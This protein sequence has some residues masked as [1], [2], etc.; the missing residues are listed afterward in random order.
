LPTFRVISVRTFALTQSP[1]GSQMRGA[2]IAI[3]A[4]T[5]GTGKRATIAFDLRSHAIPKIGSTYVLDA[6]PNG[7]EGVATPVVGR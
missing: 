4:G 2:R 1:A 3:A 6:F 7:L 5:N